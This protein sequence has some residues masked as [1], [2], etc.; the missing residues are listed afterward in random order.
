V[1]KRGTDDVDS[2]ISNGESERIDELIFVVHGI[3]PVC[4][5]KFRGIV[6]CGMRVLSVLF[7]SC[8]VWFYYLCIILC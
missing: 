8:A 2:N 7:Y 4:D 1:V 5:L 3:G 6:E